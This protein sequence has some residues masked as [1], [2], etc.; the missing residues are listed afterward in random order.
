MLLLGS[1]G[2]ESYN[3]KPGRGDLRPWKAPLDVAVVPTG[4]KT[5]YRMGRDVPSDTNYW[6][7]WTTDVH[8]VVGGNADETAERT[9]YTGDGTP[10]W[11]N[12]TL[13][14]AS[15]PYPTAARELGVPAPISA[16]TLVASGG[17]STVTED[18]F[19][20][21]TY[22]TDIG[23]ESANAPASLRLTCKID[24]TVTI[25]SLAQPPAGNYGI[26]QIRVY[27]TQ[28]SDGSFF[29]LREIG[30]TSIGT[31][32]DNRDLGGVLE[33]A[34]WLMPP[35]D[36]SNLTGLWNNMLAGISG[37]SLRFCESGVY[38]AWPIQYEILPTNAQP[39][40]LATY[41][42]N[43]VM[44]TDGNPSVVTGSS[45]DAMD[46]MPVEFL[47]SCVAPKSAVS[48]GHGV[49]WASPDG[50]AYLGN[51]GARMLT[52]GVMT[53]EDWRAI[54]PSSI[55]G[56]MFE[57]RYVGFYTVAAE[58]KA[59][60]I[61]PANPDGIYF[62]DFGVDAVFIDDLQDTMY[63]L[64]G[65]NIQKWDAGAAKTV[66][67]KSK[68]FHQPKP[69]PG[70]AC[71]EVVAGSYPATFK[72]YADGVLKHTQTVTSASPFRLPGGYHAQDFQVEVSTTGSIQFV[73][74][75][76]SMQELAAT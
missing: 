29:F 10:K 16:C 31:T 49:A 52:E 75:A 22:V 41:G 8:C 47:Q 64:D 69:V 33:T 60:I 58:R 4:R 34:T 13:A 17:V 25:G 24:D 21:Y 37:R 50:L 1:V 32:D 73:A 71:A 70:F 35:A 18:R 27:R 44:L 57:R 74:M 62:L 53:Q 55:I 19:Y 11:T 42:Q 3:Q 56:R 26:T 66:T 51:S 14:L 23:E 63:V 59:F 61:D 6:L 72:L 76:H 7:S 2:V 9:Y 39:V 48:M 68:V 43:L 54:N 20:T 65:V 15:T 67:F 45:P 12:T 46:E 38:Y 5:I 40:T 36:L 30:S 28:G